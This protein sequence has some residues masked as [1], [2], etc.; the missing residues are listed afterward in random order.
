MESGCCRI[1]SA[2][3]LL[4]AALEGTVEGLQVSTVHGVQGLEETLGRTGS[5]SN[6]LIVDVQGRGSRGV[7]AEICGNPSLHVRIGLKLLATERSRVA[8]DVQIVCRKI[9]SAHASFKVLRDGVKH[10]PSGY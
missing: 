5:E 2:A 10:C 4:S 8:G 7:N 9:Q 1:I 3:S 6:V